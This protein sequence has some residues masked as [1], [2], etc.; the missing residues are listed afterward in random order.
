MN[1]QP[2]GVAP[3]IHSPIAI[4]H[5][6]NG[7]CATNAGPLPQMCAS[8]SAMSILSAFS[9]VLCSQPYFSRASASLA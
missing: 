4:I 7:G 8:G 2:N 1:R 5:L 9:T 6:P 3:N